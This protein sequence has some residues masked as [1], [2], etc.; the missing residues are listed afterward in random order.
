[1]RSPFYTY[2]DNQLIEQ[3]AANTPEYMHPN[4]QPWAV[5]YEGLLS[6][7]ECD[8]I[9]RTQMKIEP[10]EFEHCGAVTR[11]CNR[12]L[13]ESLH[14]IWSFIHQMNDIFWD[15]DVDPTGGA[16]LQTYEAGGDYQLHM[17][18]SIGQTRKL[19]AVA[20]LS[21]PEDYK[22]GDLCLHV[23]PNREVIPNTRGTICVFPHWLIHDVTPVTW[24]L[25][26]TINLGL[27]GPP[28]K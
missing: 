24:G 2:P 9:V 28:F 21:K 22:G 20:M 14:P 18:G 12:P 25:R 6:D 23:V 13:H 26:Q 7:A 27:W 17:D 10:Y 3:T 15:F 4:E 11:E 5:V 16:W 19:T 8:E 1:M